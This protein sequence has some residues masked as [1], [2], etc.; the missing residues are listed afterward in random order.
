MIFPPANRYR[1]SRLSIV[2]AALFRC[3]LTCL[4]T[5]TAAQSKAPR[6]KSKMTFNIHMRSA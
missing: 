5:F 3:R 4:A 2:G 6:L 1:K